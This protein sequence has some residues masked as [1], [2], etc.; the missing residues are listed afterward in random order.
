[1]KAALAVG[2]WVRILPC[3]PPLHEDKFVGRL[4]IVE[5]TRWTGHTPSGDN[6]LY[7]VKIQKNKERHFWY[8]EDLLR[9]GVNF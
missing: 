9:M 5:D 8:R 3:F 2:D 6:T 4:G 1:M 7:V